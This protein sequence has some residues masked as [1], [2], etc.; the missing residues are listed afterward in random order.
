MPNLFSRTELQN[1]IAATFN[2]P[3]AIQ[4]VLGDVT[5]P[6]NVQTW[7]SRLKLLAGV[8]INYLVPDEGMLPPESIRFFY[9]DMNWVAA[10]VDGAF[11]IGRNLTSSTTA[12]KMNVDRAVSAT[13][14]Q[15]AAAGMARIR[16]GAFGVAPPALTLDVVSGFLLRS[17]VVISCPGIGVYT[18]DSESK[19]LTLLRFERLGPA[20]DTLICLV[21]GDIG[22]ADIHEPP[23]GLHYGIDQY[24]VKNG[25]VQASKEVHTFS[26]D[27]NGNV[28]LNPVAQSEPIGT[29]F[30]SVAP[31]TLRIAALDTFI[32]K[33]SQLAQLDAAQM[34]FE[35]TQGVGMVSFVKRTAWI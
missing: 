23:E 35:M 14:H 27:Q 10:L 25:V 21:D 4:Q 12:A 13:V 26:T 8:P 6:P 32:A 9:L 31:R 17:S 20:S 7:L 11:S 24:S 18:Y 33:L 1:R 29:Y 22:Q 16:A 15:Q 3:A 19:P 34:G 30:R 28:K 5:L 2:D